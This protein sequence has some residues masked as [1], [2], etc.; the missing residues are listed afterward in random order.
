M[1]RQL[2][3]AMP[4]EWTQWSG[5]VAAAYGEIDEKGWCTVAGDWQRTLEAVAVPMSAPLHGLRLAF[6]VTVPSYSAEAKKLDT[7]IGPRLLEMVRRVEAVL[8]LQ[9]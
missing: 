4:E 3:H 1:E 8:G 5:G 7:D 6:S 9:Q 2:Q